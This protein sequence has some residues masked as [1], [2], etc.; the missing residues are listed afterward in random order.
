VR[1]NNERTGKGMKVVLRAVM[2]NSDGSRF[3]GK[4]EL[5]L[6]FA[7]FAGLFIGLGDDEYEVRTVSWD[8][9]GQQ[10]D[11]LPSEQNMFGSRRF[12]DKEEF[13][14]CVEAARNCGFVGQ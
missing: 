2:A 11:V 9:D 13:D 10:F 12:K 6:P 1:A 5:D 3:Y 14:S 4:L 7:P 8:H